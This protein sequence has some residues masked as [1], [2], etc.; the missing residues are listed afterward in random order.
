M[1]PTP[2]LRKKGAAILKALRRLYPQAH[3]EL[4]FGSPLELAVAAILSAQCTDRRVNMVTPALFKKYRTAEDWAHADLAVL[5]K[6]IHSTGFFRNKAKNIKAL[7]RAL[8][9]RYGGALP[10]ELETLITLPGIGRKTANVLLISAF[11]KPGVTVDT[12]CTRVSRRLGLTRS[13]SPEKI[14]MDL[15]NLFAE[16]D[17]ADLSHCLVFHGRY[18]CK[19]RKP[20]CAQCPLAKLCPSCELEN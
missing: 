4:V 16:K 17:W 2:A 18:C 6:E 15:K 20:L 12:H 3:C 11:G 14:E 5:E 1:K 7:G 10:S 19:A 9:D 13:L 8:C